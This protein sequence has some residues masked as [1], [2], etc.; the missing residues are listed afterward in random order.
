[1]SNAGQVWPGNVVQLRGLKNGLLNPVG[2]NFTDRILTVDVPRLSVNGA[3]LTRIVSN[4]NYGTTLDT[5]GSILRS[6]PQTTAAEMTFTASRIYNSN[7]ARFMMGLGANWPNGNINGFLQEISNSSK[8]NL[9]YEFN[10]VYYTAS[11]ERPSSPSAFLHCDSRVSP[12]NIENYISSDNPPAYISSVTYGRRVYLNIS[13]SHREED[14]KRTLDA[15]FNSALTGGNIQLND[16]QRQIYNASSITAIILGGAAESATNLINLTTPEQLHQLITSGANFSVDSP[17]KPLSYTVRYL[18][19]NTVAQIGIP[20]QW[21]EYSENPPL[22]RKP[23]RLTISGE[24]FVFIDTDDDD[25]DL[26]WKIRLEALGQD[27]KSLGVFERNIEDRHVYQ[28][29]KEDNHCENNCFYRGES[30]YL[31]EPVFSLAY[32]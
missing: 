9:L 25:E 24:G 17:A 18:K 4:A 26:D 28:R 2:I 22:Y 29:G 21:N 30:L 20:G 27:G 31:N 23:F 10:Q 8:T 6:L 5:L 14:V 15:A 13:S 32:S 7:H 12:S 3:N 19:D 11:V 16:E 1:M